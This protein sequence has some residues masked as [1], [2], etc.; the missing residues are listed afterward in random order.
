LKTDEPDEEKLSTADT[1]EL[2]SM[3]E[4]LDESKEEIR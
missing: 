1:L 2:S 3:R 4:E